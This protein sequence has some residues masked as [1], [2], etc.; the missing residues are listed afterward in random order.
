MHF[1]ISSG[2]VELVDPD[3][4]TAFHAV[5]PAGL[6]PDELAEIVR[7]EDLGEVL[8]GGGHLLIPVDTVRRM[9]AGRVGPE[10]ETNLDGMLAYAARKGWLSDD[11]TRVRAHL[12]TE[13]V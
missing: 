7:E 12:E 2:S 8:P 3:D 6:G 13:Q 10:W 5:R 9:A 1:R 4:V 11:G